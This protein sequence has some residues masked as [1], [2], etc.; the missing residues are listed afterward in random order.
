MKSISGFGVGSKSV[1][2]EV[3]NFQ[4]QSLSEIEI[5]T[6][7]EKAT[8][9]PETELTLFNSARERVLADFQGAKSAA[10]D[11]TLKEILTAQ[12][13][14]LADQELVAMIE[15][16]ISSGANAVAAITNSI[17]VFIDLL[18]DS[19]GEFRERIQDLEEIRNRLISKILSRNTSFTLPTSGRLIVV[20]DDLTPMETSKFNSSVVGVLTR[21]GGPT[22]HTAIVCR[23]LGIT[24]LVGSGDFAEIPDGTALSI[25]PVA[26][27]AK[28]GALEGSSTSRNWWDSLTKQNSP[29]FDVLA[30]VG[31]AIDAAKASTAGA[32]GIGLF[33]SELLFLEAKDEPTFELQRDL[34]LA[35][36]Q[37]CPPGPVIF[38]T[39]DAGTD[40]P[41]P[42]LQLAR[43]LNPALGIRGQRVSQF[44]PQFFENQ[45]RA[46][47][48]AA[49]DLPHISV[50]VMAPMIATASEAKLFAEMARS[51]GFTSVGVMIEVPSIVDQIGQLSDF[52]DFVSI[53]TNDLS[54]YLFAADR[55]NSALGELLDPWQPALL[56]SLQR[57]CEL[58]IASQIKVGICGEAASDPLLA[59]VLVGF[60]VSSLSGGVSAV[61]DLNEVAQ[62]L[63]SDIANEAAQLAL[64]APDRLLAKRSVAEF[65][66]SLA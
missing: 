44:H 55:Q 57:I 24:A 25:D 65:L 63:T 38:R 2:G 13:A 37:K 49:R 11:E 1:Q 48:Q 36:L 9:S 31:S 40:K 14:L 7:I 41:I 22:S 26:G 3:L 23:Q 33:R 42:F 8:Q 43:E 27:T 56:R 10:S 46:L 12:S 47:H 4:G 34:Y 15:E 32:K 17:K 16:E 58:A 54:Q 19:T 6:A 52:I 60:G 5:Q 59:P 66:I 35:V 39:L 53:G 28:L 51:I 18:Q 30:N 61:G 29:G 45:L 62:R 21:R 64:A 20:A 50:S